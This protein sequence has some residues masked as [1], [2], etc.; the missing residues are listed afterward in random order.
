MLLLY[1]T[2][3]F[4]ILYSGELLIC[5]YRWRPLNKKQVFSLLTQFFCPL[6]TKLRTKFFFNSIQCFKLCF[7]DGN[8]TRVKHFLSPTWWEGLHEALTTFS[9]LLFHNLTCVYE[10]FR[11]LELQHMLRVCLHL[12][13]ILIH[14]QI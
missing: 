9:N 12:F 3:L 11:L 7:S 5:K 6:W 8:W 1:L 14:R 2:S 13:L 4:F 10:D